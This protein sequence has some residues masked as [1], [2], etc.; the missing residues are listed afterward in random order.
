VEAKPLVDVLDLV[1]EALESVTS[2]TAALPTTS[3]LTMVGETPPADDAAPAGALRVR[4]DGDVVAVQHVAPLGRPM[5]IYGVN[6]I[7]GETRLDIELAAITGLAGST[8]TTVDDWFAPAEFDSM[9]KAERLSSPSYEAMVGGV[10]ISAG[11]VSFGD[12]LQTVTPDYEVKVVSEVDGPS[13]G[14]GVFGQLSA[15]A[16]LDAGSV[17]EPSRIGRGAR[18]M[19]SLTFAAAEIEWVVADGESGVATGGAISYRQGL[20]RLGSRRDEA[21]GRDQFMLLPAH[22]ART[23]P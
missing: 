23:T 6:A 4:P 10:R 22:A 2:W 8:Y 18:T 20:Q 3:P 17:M 16:I 11:G 5:D 13:R 1:I 9:T 12:D 7:E 15:T 21:S 14:I 19:T